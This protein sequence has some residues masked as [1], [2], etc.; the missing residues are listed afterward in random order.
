MGVPE[1]GS[2]PRDRS[3]ARIAGLVLVALGL[4]ELAVTGALGLGMDSDSAFFLLF[5]IHLG[6]SLYDG[7]FGRWRTVTWVL[8]VAVAAGLQLAEF[9]AYVLPWGQIE[10]W[11]TSTLAPLPLIG[12]MLQGDDPSL[13]A[14]LAEAGRV[15]PFAV[16]ALDLVALFAETRRE[17]S[18]GRWLLFLLVGIAAYGALGLALDA[19]VP[20]PSADMPGNA[21]LLAPILPPW[22]ALPFYAVLRAVPSKTGG[23]IAALALLWLPILW[24]WM[25]ANALRLGPMRWPWRLLC[26]ALAA[27]WIGLGHLGAQPP[28]PSGILGAQALTVAVFAFFLL[29][30][31]VLRRLAG[32]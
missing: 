13:Q 5:Y 20:S 16:L 21:D 27:A 30:P 22:S 24:P 4:V 25:R 26:L 19:L 6:I 14:A 18:P 1:P 29:G 17:W 7:R 10:F 23:V 2:V 32:R 9:L 28:E 11:L 3:W 31:P 8:L 12:P 15:L